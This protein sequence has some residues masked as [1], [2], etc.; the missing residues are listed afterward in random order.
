MITK[1]RDSM[2]TV[3]TTT[4]A[5]QILEVSRETVRKYV[6]RGKLKPQSFVSGKY[7]FSRFG[8]EEYKRAGAYA[9][10]KDAPRKKDCSTGGQCIA[11]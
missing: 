7:L 1:E 2:E 8:I 9:K 5:A 4:E 3:I 6:K 10:P 11:L